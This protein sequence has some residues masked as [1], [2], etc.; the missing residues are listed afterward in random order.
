MFSSFQISRKISILFLSAIAASMFTACS[1]SNGASSS[2]NNNLSMPAIDTTKVSPTPT[3]SNTPTNTPSNS[4]SPTLAPNTPSPEIDLTKELEIGELEL[5]KHR[6][7]I[8]EISIPK[9]WKL[10]DNSQAGEILVTWNDKA[11]RATISS[12]IFVPPS[13]IPE[14]RLSDVFEVIIKGMYGNQAD[15]ALRSPV[16]EATGNV[17]IEWTSTVTIGNKKIKF[18]ANSKL[19]RINN[20]FVI[21]TFGAIEPKFIELKDS[22]AKISNSQTVNASLTIP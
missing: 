17:V 11:G 5:Y 12:N 10:V 8:M 3:P 19:Q 20:K 21:L 2:G 9:G 6:S 7:G 14:N 22:F 15:F 16:L 4:N 1:N 13:E 18:L